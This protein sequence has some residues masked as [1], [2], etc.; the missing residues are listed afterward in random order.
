VPHKIR[1]KET[2][3]HAGS[4]SARTRLFESLCQGQNLGKGQERGKALQ[5]G[6]D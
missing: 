6:C 1:S 5:T 4:A 2:N 3:L